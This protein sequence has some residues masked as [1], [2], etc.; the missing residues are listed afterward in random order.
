LI[1]I[2]QKKQPGI[3]IKIAT[4]HMKDMCEISKD[5]T[6]P[7]SV[8]EVVKL[9]K[10]FC[11]KKSDLACVELSAKLKKFTEIVFPRN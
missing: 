2:T 9:A 11:S 5:K 4:K 6:L 1:V 8:D 10:I 7:L 3:A